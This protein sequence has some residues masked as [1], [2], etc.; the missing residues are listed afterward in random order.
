MNVLS[1]VPGCIQF[2]V[3]GRLG[4]KGRPRF[5]AIASRVRVFTPKK[6]KYYEAIVRHFAIQALGEGIRRQLEGPLALRVNIRLQHPKRFSLKMRN[7]AVWPMGK[8]DLD[9]V[10]KLVGDA[11]NGIAYK[12]DAQIASAYIERLYDSR[13]PEQ[14]QVSITELRA[15]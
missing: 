11:L 1:I 6:T 4:G 10:L 15:C 5:A 14:V 7:A 13:Q 9:N 2:T 3:P 12:D 8:P